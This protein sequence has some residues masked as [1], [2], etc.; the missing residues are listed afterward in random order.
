MLCHAPR[1]RSCSA[2]HGLAQHAMAA[3]AEILYVWAKILNWRERRRQR[4]DM[5]EY[6]GMQQDFVFFR[7]IATDDL[8]RIKKLE[9]IFRVAALHNASRR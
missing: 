6:E 9:V 2:I 5:Q 7:P 8:V 4:R 1:S 3:I